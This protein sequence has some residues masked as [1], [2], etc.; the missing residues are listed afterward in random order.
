[1]LPRLVSVGPR[2]YCQRVADDALIKEIGRRLA[3]AT[4][5]R[6]RIVLF[7]TELAEKSTLVL[8]STSW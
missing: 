7:D 5:A 8:T 1:V 4:P 2:R 6:S 3:E